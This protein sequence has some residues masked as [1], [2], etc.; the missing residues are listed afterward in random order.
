M[1][2]SRHEVRKL[3]ECAREQRSGLRCGVAEALERRGAR[4]EGESREEVQLLRVDVQH[5]II[6]EISH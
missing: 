5:S 1:D 6:K 3:Y 4:E 2:V